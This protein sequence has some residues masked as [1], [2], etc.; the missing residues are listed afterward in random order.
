M[1][2]ESFYVDLENYVRY[3]LQILRMIYFR[4]VFDV[5]LV[6][7]STKTGETQHILV[8]NNVS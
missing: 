3:K 6:L 8:K 7:V 4:A 5:Q 2:E 1:E